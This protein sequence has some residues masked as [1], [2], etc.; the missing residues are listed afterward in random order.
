MAEDS[1]INGAGIA[2]REDDQPL[3]EDATATDRDAVVEDVS[4]E[5]TDC[6]QNVAGMA[7]DQVDDHHED[8]PALPAH[9][10]DANGDE[11]AALYHAPVSLQEEDWDVNVNIY[12]IEQRMQDLLCSELHPNTRRLFG[13]LLHRARMWDEDFDLLQGRVEQLESRHATELTAIH[14]AIGA[15]IA[16]GQVGGPV[17]EDRPMEEEA[18]PD[19]TEADRSDDSS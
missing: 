9:A 5:P 12:A 17:V 7:V 19:E 16:A 18:G 6:N 3:V 8:A 15:G 13:L 4:N 2:V 10:V 11:T 14:Q 1:T